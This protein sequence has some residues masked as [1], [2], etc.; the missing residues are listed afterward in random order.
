VS[1]APTLWVLVGPN[2]AGKST[3]YEKVVRPHFGGPFVNAD[4]MASERWPD[5]PFDHSGEAARAANELREAL[6]EQRK[7][8][9]TATVFSHP[10]RMEILRRAG[11]A[12]FERWVTWVGVELAD[13]AVARVRERVSRGGHPI[14]EEKI[15]ARYERMQALAREAV[16]TC[17]R[18]MVIDNSTRTR[19]LRLVLAF[20]RGTLTFQAK[21]VP[22]WVTQAFQGLLT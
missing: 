4:R 22:R 14:P 19:P 6:I 13:L 8:F 12:G 2:G 9:A 18:G 11:E 3:Y 16:T 5:A 17:E 7:S 21:D 1:A 20:E 15:R 10:S